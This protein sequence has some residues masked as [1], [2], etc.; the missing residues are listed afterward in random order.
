MPIIQEISG[1][2]PVKIWTNE[3]DE[4]AM[5]QAHNLSTLDFI[6]NHIA[7]MPDAHAGVGAVVG[8]VI[9]T[10]NAVIPAAVG[11]DIG[12]G[13]NAIQTSLTASDL[14]ESLRD[15]RLKL[16]SVVPTGFDQH[17][18]C[19][20]SGDWQR[21]TGESWEKIVDKNPGFSKG[22]RNA[23]ANN[24][25]QLQAGTLGGGNHFVE[26]CLDESDR[27][28]AMLHSGSRGIGNMIGSYFIR[29]AKKVMGEDIKGLAD[30][31][32][33]YLRNGHE[34]FDRYI[35]A[36]DWAQQYAFD[37]RELMM[38][39]VIGIMKKEFPQM[40]I[41]KEAINCHHNYIAKEFHYGKECFVTRKG[42]IRAYSGE[43]GIIP[44]SMGAKSFIVKGKGSLES[45]C[46]CS[47]GAGRV[48]SRTEAKKHFTIEDLRE[49]TKGV[50]CSIREEVID[51]IPGA[52]KD[53]EQ[54]MKNQSDLVEVV[55]TLKQVLCLKG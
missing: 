6:N 48:M 1:K 4:T 32:L 28:W 12:C 49:Q 40:Q 42:A 52:Y 27:V 47:H 54:V 25:W 26:V 20:G 18:E 37:N 55:H 21:A 36:V 22:L 16:E 13:C 51:E 53:I 30:K 43:L 23:S 29:E 17:N 35:E 31:N 45:F 44:G 38:R 7:L 41:T 33:A 50:E 24:K 19:I 5:Q 9:P 14:P 10:I 46:S 34:A 11:V 15:L 2:T 8:S 39:S 3:C